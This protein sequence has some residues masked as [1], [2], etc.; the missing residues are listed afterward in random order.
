METIDSLMLIFDV[1]ESFLATTGTG[2]TGTTGSK[3]NILEHAIWA[4]RSASYDEFGNVINPNRIAV[5]CRI[6]NYRYCG[7]IDACTEEEV[8]KVLKKV[9]EMTMKQSLL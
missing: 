2:N 9:K 5:F 8:E 3:G 1:F 4:E 7:N 6:G